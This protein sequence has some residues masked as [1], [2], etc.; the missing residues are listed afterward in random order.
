MTAINPA[1]VRLRSNGL[2][3]RKVGGELVV[4][5]FNSSQYFTIRG[6]GIFLFEL[7]QEKRNREELIAALLARRVI[8]P[9]A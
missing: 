7:L 3:S 2:S 1:S 9:A 4:L 6:S 8:Q 5:D